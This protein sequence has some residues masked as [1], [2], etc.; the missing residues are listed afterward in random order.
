MGYLE[1]LKTI[2]LISIILVA[3][4]CASTDPYHDVAPSTDNCVEPATEQCHR[5]YYQEHS[6]FD[7]AFVEFTER[8][9]A[10]DSDR[11]D[12]V[13]NKIREH[14]EGKGVVVITFV[15]GW[16]HNAEE[17]D[18][19]LIDF[20]ESLAWVAENSGSLYGRR[21]IGVYIGWRGASLDIPWIDNITFW[22]RKAVAE[23]VGKGGVTKLLLE[24]DQID[25]VSA[26]NTLVI[27]G[28]SFGGAIVIS[29]LS[30]VIA[31]RAISK[32]ENGVAGNTIGDGV[33]VLNPAIEANQALS[34]V[35]ASIDGEYSTDDPYFI[36]ISSDADAATH[37]TFPL[38]QTVGLLFT[39]HQHDL[40][41]PY[42]R[43]RLNREHPVLKE[44]H[45]DATTVGNFAPYL[46]HRLVVESKGQLV[47]PRLSSC[48]AY[49]RD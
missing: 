10:F 5:S 23:E 22:D 47:N 31:D 2:T 43:D 13:L 18:S 21:L 30:E 48:D 1:R 29:A 4:G 42:Y 11:V 24:L 28:H 32:S 3:T 33:I 45:L 6:D 35:E 49:R 41:R 37:Y 9:N 27:V 36:S 16:K 34:L 19:N 40:N 38:G 17:S 46:T 7:L 26:K 20:K 14:A 39:W 15:H 44:E 8:G 12:K 25:R